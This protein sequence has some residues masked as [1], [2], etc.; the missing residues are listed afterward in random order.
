MSSQASSWQV[1][2]EPSQGWLLAPVRAH[3]MR[4]TLLAMPMRLIPFLL[5]DRKGSHGYSHFK[6]EQTEA[7]RS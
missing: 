6:D 4:H 1:D 7:Q 5:N 3:C 2:K